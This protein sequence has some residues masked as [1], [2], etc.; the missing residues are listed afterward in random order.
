MGAAR[1]G[2]AGESCM[3]NDPRILDLPVAVPVE[4]ITLD[5]ATHSRTRD[6][7]A[8]TAFS[9]ATGF[10]TAHAL[11]ALAVSPLLPDL[12]R[13]G[14]LR[15]A[16]AVAAH[17]LSHRHVLGLLRF[18]A[19]QDFFKEEHG[20][21]FWP[22]PKG[23]ATFWGGGMGHLRLVVGGYGPLMARATELMRG[24]LTY[25]EGI[26]R[27]AYEVSFGASVV[28]SA[29]ID[30]AAYRVIERHG[31]R[32]I[33]D[34]GCGAGAF[35]VAWA[36]RDPRN[37]GVGVDLAP[38]AIDAAATAAAAA[39]VS[40]RLR[41]VVGD[42]FDLAGV[43]AA[44]SEVDVFYSFAL[45]HEALADGEQA[46]LDHIDQM[47]RLFAGRRYLVGEPML[48]MTQTDGAF[49]WLH[50]L[51]HQGIPRN[52]PGWCAL[53]AR[54]QHATL[55]RVYVPDHQKIGAYFDVRLGSA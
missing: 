23:S 29:L 20:E 41:F 14:V 36:R 13:D 11:Y 34:L 10:A 2:R 16:P 21:A 46:L 35:L 22:T 28:T 8:S 17:R 7:E 51:S 42:G 45:E 25:G 12:E 54:L 19:T 38:E 3:A 9:L 1:M 37:H 50:I 48:N 24:D 39:G 18:L 47:G 4:S 32:S 27:N 6:V 15:V 40:D 31:A 5:A 44:C 30:E 43:S 53:L 26:Q 33:A 52:I 49:Y 55:E